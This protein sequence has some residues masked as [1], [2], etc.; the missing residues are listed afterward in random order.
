VERLAVRQHERRRPCESVARGL[1]SSGFRQGPFAWNE[2]EVHIFMAMVA[3]GYL[4][5]RASRPPQVHAPD[6]AAV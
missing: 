6:A 5:G 4:D 1:R 3:R 2:D